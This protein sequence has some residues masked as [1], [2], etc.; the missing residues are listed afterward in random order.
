MY[1]PFNEKWCSIIGASWEN[2]SCYYEFTW[3]TLIVTLITL[4][5]ILYRWVP[6]VRYRLRYLKWGIVAI[7]T[8]I[9]IIGLNRIINYIKDRYKNFLIRYISKWIVENDNANVYITYYWKETGR[10]YCIGFPNPE[11]NSKEMIHVQ[12]PAGET[13]Q[14]HRKILKLSGP[15]CDFHGINLTPLDLGYTALRFTVKHNNKNKAYIIT[16]S[17]PLSQYQKYPENTEEINLNEQKTC[18]N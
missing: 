4:F 5:Y 7:V 16:E 11:N 9:K 1:F 8:L 14:D 15:G 3:A 12:C 10:Y 2:D 17:V 18:N 6:F 13:M